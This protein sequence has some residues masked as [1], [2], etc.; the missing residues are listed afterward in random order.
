MN[1]SMQRPTLRLIEES[2][3]VLSCHC[4]LAGLA[5]AGHKRGA[6][7]DLPSY[8]RPRYWRRGPR[9]V[10][11]VYNEPQAEKAWSRLLAL[12]GKALS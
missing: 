9:M 12:H 11:S 2:M 4:H 7:S 10:P 5:G 8:P 6:G 1:T 3:D